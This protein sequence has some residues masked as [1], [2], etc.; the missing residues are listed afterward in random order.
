MYYYGRR[1]PRRR[2]T[3]TLMIAVAMIAL[4]AGC[5]VA[6]RQLNHVNLAANDAHCNPHS[7]HGGHR[8]KAAQ[9]T[10]ADDAP[11]DGSSAPA[12]DASS[13]GSSAPPDETSSDRK[14]PSCNHQSPS[15][16]PVE[17]SASAGDPGSTSPSPSAS[18]SASQGVTIIGPLRDDYLDIRKV[19]PNVKTPPA[20][21]KASKGTFTSNC[22]RNQNHHQNNDNLVITPGVPDGA[23]H[24][25]DLVGNLSANAQSTNESLAASGTTCDN[26][27]LST[28]FW[29]VFRNRSAKDDPNAPAVQDKNN[30]GTPILPTKVNLTFRGNPTTKVVASPRFIGEITGDAKSITNGLGNTRPAYTCTGM[31]N[32]ITNKYPL[33]PS[34]R[35]LEVIMDFPSCW[36][37]ANLDSAN[38][39]DHIKFPDANTG[40][41]PAGTKAVPQLRMTLTYGT[42]RNRVLGYALDGFATERHNSASEHAGFINVMPEKLLAKVAQCINTGRKCTR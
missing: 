14:A 27:D 9:S 19:R 5:I 26:G 32:R 31:E 36:D 17:P 39:R 6:S 3:N 2:R 7:G 10:P 35:S 11:S 23:H 33:C 24:L 28:Y 12:D 29:P 42:A 34:G 8:A 40:A 41:C 25:H 38:H 20:R 30:I 18:A 37:G 21:A 13:E 16:T 1:A 22:G 15:A 4:F